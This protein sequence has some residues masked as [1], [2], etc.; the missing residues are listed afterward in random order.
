M[1]I[2]GSATLLVPVMLSPA[3]RIFYSYFYSGITA[4][5][6]PPTAGRGLDHRSGLAP[7]KVY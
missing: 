7:P 3:S 5:W 2:L 6:V 1:A 4:L